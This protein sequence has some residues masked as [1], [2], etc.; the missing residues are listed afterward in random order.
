MAALS[1][2]LVVLPRVKKL[3]KGEGLSGDER[4]QLI[5]YAVLLSDVCVGLTAM[6]LGFP[7]IGLA[8]LAL[9]VLLLIVVA[10]FTLIAALK[11]RR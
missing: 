6:A 3:R 5:A 10:V 2:V 9:G 4:R 8:A 1:I 7:L 11:H